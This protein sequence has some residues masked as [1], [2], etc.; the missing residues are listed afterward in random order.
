MTPRPLCSPFSI[1]GVGYMWRLSTRPGFVFGLDVFYLWL[2]ELDDTFCDDIRLVDRFCIILRQSVV[3][4]TFYFP[5]IL[6]RPIFEE[7]TVRELT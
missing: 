4:W 7:P 6:H 5:M 3:C 1:F 2:D